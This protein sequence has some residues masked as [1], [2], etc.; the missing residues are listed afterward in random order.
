MPYDIKD[1][2]AYLKYYYKEKDAGKRPK[3][4][5]K[6]MQGKGG[7]KMGFTGANAAQYGNLS[8]GDAEAI[9]NLLK[10]KG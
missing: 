1:K 2:K 3:T 8:K 7:E 10:K 9:R 6:W 4:F 5:A